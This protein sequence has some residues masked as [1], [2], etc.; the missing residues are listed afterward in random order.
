MVLCSEVLDNLVLYLKVPEGM[1]A[2]VRNSVLLTNSTSVDPNS[3]NT[4]VIQFLMKE[5]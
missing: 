3:R 2:F 5:R 4:L 1:I